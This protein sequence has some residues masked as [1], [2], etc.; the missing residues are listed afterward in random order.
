MKKLIVLIVLATLALSGCASGKF[1]GFLATTDYV[2]AEAKATQAKQAAEIAAL[3]AQLAEY[4]SVKDQAQAAIDQVNKT[5]KTIE[6]LQAIAQK[7]EE[8]IGSI[9]KE[10]IKQIIDLLQAALQ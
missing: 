9:P 7:A 6:D 10:V 8:R 5:Q 4:Q 1:L 2:D 3:Q